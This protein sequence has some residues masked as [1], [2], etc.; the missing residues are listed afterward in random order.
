M[1]IWREIEEGTGLVRRDSESAR[2]HFEKALALDPRNGLALKSLGD[3]ALAQGRTEDAISSYRASAETGFTHPDLGG[4][5]ARALLT[6][7][8]QLRAEGRAA[9]AESLLRAALETAPEDGTILNELGSV[10][11][12]QGR[13][14][15]ARNAFE[16]SMAASPEAP[17]P[18]RNLAVLLGPPDAERLLREAIAREP[19]YALARIDLARILAETGRLR[20][21]GEEIEAALRLGPGDPEA[22]FLA[23]RIADLEGRREAARGLYERFLAVAPEELAGPRKLAKERL[24]T[25]KR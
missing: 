5:L 1:A 18:R 11:A 6:K 24:S 21:G 8:Q 2:S 22:I 9:E 3:V 20:E 19:G 17:E 23:A 10:L 15:E 7:G 14:E 12:Q 4:S 25:L 13:R 16:R